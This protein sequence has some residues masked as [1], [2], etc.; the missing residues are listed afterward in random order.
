MHLEKILNYNV[1]LPNHVENLSLPYR[2]LFF[3]LSPQQPEKFCC[4]HT[5]PTTLTSEIRAIT[6]QSGHGFGQATN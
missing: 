6:E 2:S 5:L 1:S 3:Y 4:C